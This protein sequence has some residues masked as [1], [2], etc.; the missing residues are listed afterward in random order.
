MT[1]QAAVVGLLIEKGRIGPQM[2]FAIADG[3]DLAVT[4]SQFL[5]VPILDARFADLR[6]ELRIAVAQP[7]KKI[8]V[9]KSELEKKIELCRS[10]LE[11]KIELCESRLEKKIEVS[12][13]ELEKKIKVAKADL[14]RWV[15]LVMLGNVAL[16]A[17][18]TAM[19]SA[20]QHSH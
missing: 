12:R 2:A 18:A 20:L 17:G 19:L 3:I 16:T 7:D 11:K 6:A 14:V 10:E 5:T 4:Q 13:S 15:F 1:S 9:V 8:D